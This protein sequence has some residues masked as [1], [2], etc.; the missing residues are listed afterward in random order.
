MDLEDG[1][2]TVRAR[3]TSGA[4]LVVSPRKCRERPG[5]ERMTTVNA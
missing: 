3:T 5:K 4:K 2:I 1:E